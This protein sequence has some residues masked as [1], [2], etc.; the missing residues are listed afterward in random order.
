LYSAVR[1]NRQGLYRSRWGNYDLIS[2][3]GY[4][5]AGPGLVSADILASRLQGQDVHR[6]AFFGV[7]RE[8]LGWDD[9]AAEEALPEGVAAIFA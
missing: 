1:W 8:E 9:A 5:T 4:L 3:T 2:N 6:S 7:V